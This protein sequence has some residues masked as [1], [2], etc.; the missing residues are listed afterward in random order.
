MRRNSGISRFL[1]L[2]VFMIGVLI[3]PGQ[4]LGNLQHHNATPAPG[5]GV[6]TEVLG[7]GQPETAS[8]QSLVLLRVTFEPGAEA[9]PH[10]HP[11]ASVFYIESGEITFMLV[12]GVA[13]LTPAGGTPDA[14]SAT[15][16]LTAGSEVVLQGG[17]MVYYQADAVLAERNDGDESVVILISNLRGVD[18]P[19]R[20]PAT[21]AS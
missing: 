15:E 16:E 6:T 19:A 14:P 2:L 11:G 12:G 20:L 4:A 5:T 1:V 18:E 21:P 3:A 13:T 9:A 10:T 17:D 8:G 7:A